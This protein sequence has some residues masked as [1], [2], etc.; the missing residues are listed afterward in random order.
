MRANFKASN[1]RVG[2]RRDTLN[3]NEQNP[4]STSCEHMTALFASRHLKSAAL[5]AFGFLSMPAAS[6]CGGYQKENAIELRATLTWFCFPSLG[7]CAAYQ[8]HLVQCIRQI[9]ENLVIEL[10]VYGVMAMQPTQ[11][12]AT[13]G[14]CLD[15]R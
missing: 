3:I 2:V 7:A 13:A 1:R 5:S 12:N 10:Q 9:G 4:S 8:A 11:G 15:A 14:H 6:D